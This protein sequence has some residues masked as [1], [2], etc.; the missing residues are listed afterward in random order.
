MIVEIDHNGH[1]H[2][3]STKGLSMTMK[4]LR[5]YN[6][7]K[8]F[9]IKDEFNEIIFR[10]F[11][12]I[13]D[14]NA[15]NLPKD[16]IKDILKL[17]NNWECHDY[18]LEHVKNSYLAQYHDAYINIGGRRYEINKEL[19]ALNS[20]LYKSY[21]DNGSQEVFILD[22]EYDEKAIEVFL[23]MIHYKTFSIPL[24]STPNVLRIC[25]DMKC[26][27]LLDILGKTEDSDVILRIIESEN[28][29]ENS[30]S[31]YENI[32]SENIDR[33][34]NCSECAQIPANCLCR[35]F[36]KAKKLP[37]KNDLENFLKKV[38]SNQGIKVEMLLFGINY[39][40]S[41]EFLQELLAIIEKTKE[42][43]LFQLSLSL[44][45]RLNS[46]IETLKNQTL[47]KKPKNFE[48]NIHIAAYNGNIE[49][50]K[51]LIMNSTHIDFP[52]IDGTFQDFNMKQCSP[53]HF[54]A[55]GGHENV[56]KYLIENNCIVDALN[57]EVY[58][59]LKK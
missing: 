39:E 12:E 42:R 24:N 46:S 19:M 35:I 53:L 50:V 20:E 22:N 51:Y 32:I 36:Q 43:I 15:H 41:D 9:F 54:A 58:I 57:D 38:A 4:Y 13:L 21:I 55:L 34:I 44:I 5:D 27:V 48:E 52:F 14:N 29:N 56:V 59:D 28:I 30:V 3:V 6:G 1:L 18:V 49:S 26:T 40:Y 10:L 31:V 45:K 23:E 17:M 11:L 16:H 7:M 47:V 33:F 37:Q 25:H 8:K 2:Q